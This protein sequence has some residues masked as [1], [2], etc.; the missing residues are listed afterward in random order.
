[1]IGNSGG[2]VATTIQSK[3]VS[4]AASLAGYWKLDYSPLP[5]RLNVIGSMSACLPVFTAVM[6]AHQVHQGT[7]TCPFPSHQ[8]I[9]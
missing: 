5:L 6:L 9:R 7:C 4:F 2:S 8:A 1:M 3:A